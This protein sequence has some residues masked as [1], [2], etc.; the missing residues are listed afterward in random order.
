MSSRSQ[1][2]HILRIIHS[3]LHDVAVLINSTYGFSLLLSTVWELISII[4]AAN[5]L[6]EVNNADSEVDVILVVM[7][8]TS[9]LALITIL[10]VSGSLAVN[11]CSHSPV[12]MQKV[13][14]RDDTD[15]DVVK[16]L[17]RMFTRFKVMKIEFSA[18]EMYKIDLSFISGI[19]GVT[20]SYLILFSQL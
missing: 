18:C 17:E 2:L 7:M 10:A 16:E 20:L 3:Q 19:I 8:S 4:S 1:H 12:I 5:C 15:S 6:I 14:L 9:F 13:M 11:E